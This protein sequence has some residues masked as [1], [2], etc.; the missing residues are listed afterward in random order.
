M[1]LG[2]AADKDLDAIIPLLPADAHYIVTRADT[3]RA[4]PA[5]GLARFFPGA[6]V[7]PT[8][9]EAVGKALSLAGPGDM[10][11]IGGSNF[12]VGEALRALQD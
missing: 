9:A 2:F 10:V 6:E 4:M 1:V 8:V 7:A 12:V 11:F 3:P 5:A